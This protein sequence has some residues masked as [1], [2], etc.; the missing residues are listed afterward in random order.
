ML[1]LELKEQLKTVFAALENK[2]QLIYAQSSHAD[3]AGLVEMIND[4]A[5]ASD[6]ISVAQGKTT[7]DRAPLFQIYENDQATGITFEGIPSGHEFT[8]LIL[9]ILNTDGKGKFPDAKIIERIKKIKGPVSI[10]TYISLTC[11]NCPDVVQALNLMSLI[12]P[13]FQHKMI[14]GGYVQDEIARLG[15]QGV[16]SVIVNDKLMHS[17]RITF[18]DLLAKVEET[19]GVEKS[20]DSN[21]LPQ[22]L[23]LYDVVVVGGGPAGASAAI[24]VNTAVMSVSPTLMAS[25]AVTVP[26]NSSMVLANTCCSWSA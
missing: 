13:K 2:I 15:I 5:T 14:D 22:D 26:P 11:E 9:A 1:D 24:L 23:G 20:D 6:K 3:Q 17:G 18:I 19:F 4:V 7:N 25:R 21:Q 12:H 8:S 10:E 16:P